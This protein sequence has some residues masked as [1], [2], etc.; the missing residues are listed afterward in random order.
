MALLEINLD[1]SPRQIRQFAF[2][3]LPGLCLV[4]ATIA[5]WRFDSWPSAGAL[6]A[7][8]VASVALG[9]ARPRWMRVAYIGWMLAAFPIGWLVSHALLA[10]IFYLVMTPIGWCMRIMGHDP[11]E[12]QFDREAET[13]WV[14]RSQESDPSRYFRQF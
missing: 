11:L 13:Y 1:P 10:A 3:A 5:L 9:L 2:I 8:G 7:V 6:A 14:P 4:L 12:R